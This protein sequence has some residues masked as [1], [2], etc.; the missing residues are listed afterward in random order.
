MKG[1]HTMTA[2]LMNIHQNEQ[3]KNDSTPPHL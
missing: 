1:K 2:V 3:I